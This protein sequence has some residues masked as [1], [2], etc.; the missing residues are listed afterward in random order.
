MR[1]YKKIFNRYLPIYAA[2]YNYIGKTDAI[3]KITGGNASFPPLYINIPGKGND[4]YYD[5]E[6]YEIS[7]R[8]AFEHFKENPDEIKK[9]SDDYKKICE[10]NSDFVKKAQVKDIKALFDINADY[11]SPMMTIL[12]LIGREE[13]DEEMEDIASIAKDIRY[14]NDKLLYEVGIKIFELICEKF[15]WS[16][17]D[18]NA[19]YIT[20]KE[21]LSRKA[22]SIEKINQRRKSWVLLGGKEIY[23]GGKIEE[24]LLK[25]DI[26][27]EKEKEIKNIK[28]IDQFKGSVAQKGIAKGKVRIVFTMDDLHKV[29]K[30]DIIVSSMTGPDFMVAIKKS[31][32]IITDEGGITCHAAI[33]SRELKIPAV[34]GTKI[35]TKVLKD[36]DLVEVDANQGIIKIIK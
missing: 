3:L 35:A 22:P 34:I 7:S 25:N 18:D 24:F 19:D 21:A 31:S 8:K 29:K 30:G 33:V 36:G 5:K 4:V 9:I 16:Q 32:A 15:S 11:I 28:N 26:I 20:I 14:W 12:I 13:Y 1:V 27:L 10:V 2:E 17:K 23:T 6:L